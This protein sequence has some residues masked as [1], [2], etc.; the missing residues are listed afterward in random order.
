MDLQAPFS[1]AQTIQLD[2]TE[3][4]AN[5]NLGNLAAG[6]LSSPSQTVLA[7][8]SNPFPFTLKAGSIYAGHM[9][10]RYNGSPVTGV[11]QAV[12]VT[13]YGLNVPAMSYVNTTAP[14][15]DT[16]SANLAG[17][18]NNGASGVGATF[19]TALANI[20]TDNGG[21]VQN[22]FAYVLMGQ[23]S[24]LQNGIYVA[25]GV[26]VAIVFTRDT[27]FD[28][29]AKIAAGK[30]TTTAGSN[31]ICV[32]CQQFGGTIG[33]SNMF[34]VQALVFGQ[35]LVDGGGSDQYW[36][37]NNPQANYAD[38]GANLSLGGIYDTNDITLAFLPFSVPFG[39]GGGPAAIFPAAVRGVILQTPLGV[40]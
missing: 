25:S 17:A 18:Y 4:E 10:H 12:N 34:F 16:I 2:L 38:T 6:P 31:S 23:A 36:Y 7:A 33:V 37:S 39:S 3:A 29:S 40:S 8:T 11:L 35:Q 28:T 20:I 13:G 14:L 1:L 26:G 22:G 19:T 32:I 15:A 21:T 9:L 30:Y 24:R 27:S 5:G